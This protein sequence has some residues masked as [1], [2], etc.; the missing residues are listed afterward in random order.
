MT[1]NGD[2]RLRA[3]KWQRREERRRRARRRIDMHGAGLRSAY[4]DAIRKRLTRIRAKQ[5][6]A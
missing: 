1:E 4:A 2:D 5:S 6:H 3:L